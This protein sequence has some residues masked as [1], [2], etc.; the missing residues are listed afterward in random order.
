LPLA[1]SLIEAH[2][3]KMNILSIVGQGTSVTVTI[4]KDRVLSSLAKRADRLG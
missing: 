3:G 1:K 2:G 4:P